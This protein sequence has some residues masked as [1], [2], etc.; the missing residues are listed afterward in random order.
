MTIALPEVLKRLIWDIQSMVELADDPR[1]I[2]LIGGD[3]FARALA[4]KDWLP[5]V[6]SRADAKAP[7]N[8]QVYADAM[9]RFS[10]VATVLAPGQATAPS[11]EPFWRMLGV[12]SGEA[13][14]TPFTLDA[15]NRLIPG[16]A[17]NLPAGARKTFR[18]GGVFAL[19]NPSAGVPAVVLTIHGGEIGKAERLIF[20]PNGAGA[21]SASGY[22]NG[23]I[24][25]FDIFT[26]QTRIED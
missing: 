17:Q 21:K 4:E 22:D 9:E 1:E 3:I 7:Q 15:Q 6:F 16:A 13:T 10:I 20:E 19:S 24:P 23:E 14:L 26:I 8:F 25:P 12:I 18:A 11:E 5:E 2:L